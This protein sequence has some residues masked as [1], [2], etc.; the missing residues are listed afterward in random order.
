MK[1]DWAVQLANQVPTICPHLMDMPN[2]PKKPTEQEG[3]E[4]PVPFGTTVFKTVALSRSATAPTLCLSAKNAPGISVA[5]DRAPF[6]RRPAQTA[7][8]QAADLLKLAQIVLADAGGQV[9][10]E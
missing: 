5:A 10:I 9:I 8:R 6:Y 1:Q 4:P 2:E 3:F 7:S